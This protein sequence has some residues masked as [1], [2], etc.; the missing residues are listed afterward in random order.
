MGGDTFPRTRAEVG[1]DILDGGNP[2]LKNWRSALVQSQSPDLDVE[3]VVGAALVVWFDKPF[4]SGGS[5]DGYKLVTVRESNKARIT[6]MD[7]DEV[8]AKADDFI[9][10]FK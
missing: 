10:K 5:G 9:N 1:V 3:V 7:D 4:S 2:P 6:Q 8:D